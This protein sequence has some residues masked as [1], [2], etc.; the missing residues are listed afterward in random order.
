MSV[1]KVSNRGGNIIGK[2]PGFAFA[3][4]SAIVGKYGDKGSAESTLGKQIAQKVWDSEGYHVGI[5]GKARAK[6]PGKNLLTD[7]AEDAAEKYCKADRPGRAGDGAGL[8]VGLSC[9]G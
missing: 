2:F 7:E 8:N 6:Q 1:R 5:I 4:F 9:H 3:F